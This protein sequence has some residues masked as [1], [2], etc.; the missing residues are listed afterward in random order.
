MGFRRVV[1]R[2]RLGRSKKKARAEG[3]G[4]GGAGARG[5]F[6]LG[7]AG[8]RVWV[9]GTGGVGRRG[10]GGGGAGSRAHLRVVQRQPAGGRGACR[11]TAVGSAARSPRRRCLRV[12]C[13]SPSLTAT[14]RWRRS[15]R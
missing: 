12:A 13:S 3:P 2:L 8:T 7:G 1:F 4:R 14:S 5:P 6:R 15:P 9:G 11:R 10:G